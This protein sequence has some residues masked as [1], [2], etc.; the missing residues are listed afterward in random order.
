MSEDR[1]IAWL[2]RRADA[3]RDD[4]SSISGLPGLHGVRAHENEGSRPNLAAE[5]GVT[6][7]NA[8][9]EEPEIRRP[10]FQTHDQTFELNGEARRPGL[11]WH[12][13]TSPKG[14]A[15]PEPV[16]DW[17]ASPIHATAQTA[18]SE[19]NGWGLLLR[20][21]DPLGKWREW[22]A[23]LELL[24]GSGEELRRELLHL[25]VR[26]D[27]RK[28][29]LLSQWIMGQYPGEQVIAA[30]H[31]GWHGNATA[32]VL[33]SR[34]IGLGK[35]R[36]QA[37][38]ARTDD[39]RTGGSL[40]GWR[41]E[42]AAPCIGNPVAALAVCMA[43]AGPLLKLAALQE[44]GGAGIHL[45]G[46][47][48]QGKTSVLQAVGSVWGPPEFVRTWRATA[49]G[50]EGR[51]AALNDTLMIL[52]EISECDPREIGAVVYSIANGLGKQ[53]SSRTGAARAPAR[54]RLMALSSGERSLAAHMAEGG[55]RAK[56]GQ[57]A[58]L[59]DLPATDRAHGAFDTLHQHP[60]GR[61]FADALKQA[62]ARHYGHAGPAFV[63]RLIVETR[64]L[65]A[66]RAQTLD[67]PEFAGAS[68]LEGR[69]AAVFALAGMAGEL[70]TDYG[71]LP[72]PEGEA[73]GAALEGFR[74]W[75][76]ARG[77][78]HTETRQI[79]EAVRS[80]IERHGDARFSNIRDK[81]SP[82]VRDRAGYW[83]DTENRRVWMLNS[84]AL[85]EAGGG[86]DVTRI[87]DALEEAGWLS[88]RDHN[89]RSRVKRTPAGPRRLYCIYPA[90]E[91]QP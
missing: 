70:A 83:E 49:N 87:A 73:M 18:D 29:N 52:D 37:S 90:L 27:P 64:D 36:F 23:P 89:K 17:I 39:Y 57:E 82:P 24:A 31:T 30:T 62:S 84:A 65:P 16:D 77:G 71:V 47:S 54:W 50:L 42:V 25:G 28:R 81:S 14:D 85:R 22:A 69:A 48:S 44:T 5:N 80:Y 8:R 9:F 58:R 68:G 78:A 34:T 4:P 40:D 32:F 53:R 63:E 38:H 72:W 79:L 15:N 7:G 75:R 46:D 60:D 35:V 21:M 74:C 12:G 41:D 10:G 67:I 1:G 20:F 19:G 55:K 11:Y 33:P 88:E 3:L 91:S 56:A 61:S 13:W 6:A 43:F 86:F 59:L 45:R 76:D 51:A 26:I 66:L 2:D